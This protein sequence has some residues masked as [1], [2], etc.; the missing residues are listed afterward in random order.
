MLSNKALDEAS[1][2]EQAERVASIAR[3]RARLSTGTSAQYCQ[4]EACGE[5]IPDARQ[6]A[7]PGCRY[8]IECQA[9]LEQHSPRRFG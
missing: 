1:Q 5:P 3:V 9:R 4:D 8:C 2:L 7:V 6:L